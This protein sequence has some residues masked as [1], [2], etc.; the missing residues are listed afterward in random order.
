MNK[1]W[2]WEVK[3]IQDFCPQDLKSCHLVACIAGGISRSSAFVLVEKP[4]TPVAKPWEDWWGVESR[5]SWIPSRASRG[6]M[7]APPLARPLPN[8]RQLRRLAILRLQGAWN[9]G[10]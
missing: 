2:A 7:A 5:G 4:W 1:N 10:R 9:Y 8:P 3:K 6:N